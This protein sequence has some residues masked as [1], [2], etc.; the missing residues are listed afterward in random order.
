MTC[1]FG[2]RTHATPVRGDFFRRKTSLFFAN[3]LDLQRA[4]LSPDQCLAICTPQTRIRLPYVG[5]MWCP[6]FSGD[7]GAER[8]G[9]PGSF[10]LRVIPTYIIC[11][12]GTLAGFNSFSGDDLHQLR[13]VFSCR[14]ERRPRGCTTAIALSYDIE[15][16]LY[17]GTRAEWF[18]FAKSGRVL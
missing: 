13:E 10:E 8:G 17:R 7:G 3:A 4:D 16:L 14:A 5:V 18:C 15:N 2:A 9:P 12:L 11:T 1:P 6:L